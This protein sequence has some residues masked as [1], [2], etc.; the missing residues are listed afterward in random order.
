MRLPDVVMPW[1]PRFARLLI[2]SLVPLL[3]VAAGC[4]PSGSKTEAKVPVAGVG[5][6]DTRDGRVWVKGTNVP[7]S[8]QL[9]ETYTNGVV[10]A[11][12]TIRDGR[13]EGLMRGY[14]D[15]GR[16]QVEETFVAGVSDGVRRK[17]YPDGTPKSKEE[18]SRGQLHGAYERYHANGQLAERATYR[19][20][21]PDG[22]AE[23]WDEA[24][25]AVARVRFEAGRVVEQKFL[26][27]ADRVPA[28]GEESATL[29]ATGVV[30][31]GEAGR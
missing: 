18:I 21:Q 14:Y 5:D 4:G 24:G 16:L 13:M 25:R 10:K 12:A 8:G 31:A 15:S 6:V 20:G 22:V 27:G 26:A 9:R 30:A 1:F 11:E 7:Y 28:V 17:W 23:S 29:G 3:L 2:G 19:E